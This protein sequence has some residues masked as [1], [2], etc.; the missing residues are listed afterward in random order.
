[1]KKARTLESVDSTL[2]LC[3]E[4]R[5]TTYTSHRNKEFFGSRVKTSHF[6]RMLLLFPYIDVKSLHCFDT[7]CETKTMC[8]IFLVYSCF[9]W[10]AFHIKQYQ[11]SLQNL[12]RMNLQHLATVLYIHFKGMLITLQFH[13]TEESKLKES[14]LMTKSFQVF[15][16]ESYDGE[17]MKQIHKLSHSLS[18]LNQLFD[19]NT[20]E[21]LKTQLLA[22]VVRD[23]F[24]IIDFHRCQRRDS[25]QAINYEKSS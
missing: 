16:G 9:D 19:R 12:T 23:N 18:T 7:R 6:Q 13:W 2:S 8:W 21:S 14:Y 24:I 5:W 25:K 17:T 10:R 15:I 11:K 20:K 1:M 3:V 4:Q 22:I